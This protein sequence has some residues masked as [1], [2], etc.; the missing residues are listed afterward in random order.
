MKTFRLASVIALL[1]VTALGGTLFAGGRRTDANTL[2]YHQVVPMVARDVE[3]PPTPSPTPTATQPPSPTPTQPPP[4]AG[5]RGNPIPI[6]TSVAFVGGWQVRVLSVTPNA[7]AA[8]LAENQFND[9][10]RPGHQFFIARLSATYTGAGS[11]RFDGSFRLRAV[12]T[13]SVSRSTFVDS[14]GVIPDE[15]EDP[16][17][18]SGGT[19]TG[20][21]C[22]EIPAGDALTMTMYDDAFLEERSDVFLSLIPP[23]Q[24]VPAIPGPASPAPWPAGGTRENPVP[25]GVTVP[26]ADGWNVRVISVT[27]NGTQ[28]VLAENQFNDPP[29]PGNQFFIARVSATSTSADP[30]RFD[31]GF[32]LRAVG[33]L[34]VERTTF[35]DSCGVIPDHLEDPLVFPGGTL[36]GNICFEVP[37]VEAGSLTLFD[38]PFLIDSFGLFLSLH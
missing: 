16:T 26:F 25:I 36:T 6:G 37:G 9:P 13:S 17:V 4:A 23:G 28:Q 15:L 30:H 20:N 19:I 24:P 11:T 34:G 27:P 2:P 10:P 22:W 31:G 3:P 18:F 7:T 5:T 38:D 1:G 12:G 14:C 32:R 21:V 29:A 8:V 35:G 33:D